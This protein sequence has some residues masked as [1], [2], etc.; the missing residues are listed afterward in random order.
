MATATS[1]KL[2]AKV[3]APAEWLKARRELLTK[4]KEFTRLRDEISQR[5]RELPWEKVD[6]PY[7]FEGPRGRESLA[8]LFEGRSQLII[9]H[10]MFGPDWK[11]G[12]PSCSFLADSFD[13]SV[14]HLA[15][16]DTTFVAVSRAPLAQIEAFKKR[17][18]WRFKWWRWKSLPYLF[19]LR[20]RPRHSAECLQLARHDAQGPERTGPAASHGVGA[21][22]RP[23]RPKRADVDWLRGQESRFADARS[24][25]KRVP[26]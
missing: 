23:L 15:Q 13:G 21:P 26:R 4:E 5:R 10:F 12:C 17:M 11:E 18:G 6:K 20:P 7:V 1:E 9:Y 8:D 3:A 24:H 19:G 14:I 2:D 16:R 25:G 22:S